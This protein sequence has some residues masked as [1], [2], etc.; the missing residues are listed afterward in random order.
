MF[1]VQPMTEAAPH[2]GTKLFG[3]GGFAQVEDIERKIADRIKSAP[4]AAVERIIRRGP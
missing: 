3:D 2:T 1:G 4:I